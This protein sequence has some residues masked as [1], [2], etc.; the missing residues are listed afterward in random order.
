MIAE[1]TDVNSRLTADPA[2]K[3]YDAVRQDSTGKLLRETYLLLF[4]GAGDADDARA[5]SPQ[6]P[7][8]DVEYEWRIR[9]VSINTDGIMLLVGKVRN[10][11]SGQRPVAAGRDCS[12]IIVEDD[13]DVE[14]D[15]S[16]TP[17]LL[18]CDLLIS[19]RSNR[20]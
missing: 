4:P 15:Y 3:V 2:V 7:D 9:V 5:T 13:G 16:I 6:S 18:Y 10:L 12:P 8:S 11:L 14:P 17:P 19:F 20:A 1:Y